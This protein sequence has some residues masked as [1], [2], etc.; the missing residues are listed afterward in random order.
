M[1]TRNRPDPAFYCRF[2]RGRHYNLSIGERQTGFIKGGGLIIAWPDDDVGAAGLRGQRN[3]LGQNAPLLRVYAQGVEAE[4][5][6]LA[7]GVRCNLKKG[8]I[9]WLYQSGLY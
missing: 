9:A 7:D 6:D 1:A 8:T 2:E 4:C 5:A 3:R